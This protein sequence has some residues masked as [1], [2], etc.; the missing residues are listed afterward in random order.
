MSEINND[1]G[2]MFSNYIILAGAILRKIVTVLVC[3]F[4]VLNLFLRCYIP[5]EILYPHN[6]NKLPYVKVGDGDN[7]SARSTAKS[8][9]EFLS[10]FT[11]VSEDGFVY[12]DRSKDE[13]NTPHNTNKYMDSSFNSIFTAKDLSWVA[14]L[15]QNQ[16]K[17]QKKDFSTIFSMFF[18]SNLTGVKAQ[19]K[20]NKF[21]SMV[22]NGLFSNLKHFKLMFF[23][24]TLLLVTFIEGFID[25]GGINDFLNNKLDDSIGNEEVF[26][27]AKYIKDLILYVFSGFFFFLRFFQFLAIPFSIVLAFSYFT[28]TPI[29]MIFTKFFMMVFTFAF[30]PLIGLILADPG[31]IKKVFMTM[32]SF[33][34]IPK[35]L[36]KG[37][38]GFLTIFKIIG[39]F[40]SAFMG[41]LGMISFLPIVNV[42]M[43]TIV[44][45]SY[46][47]GLKW[48]TDTEI[49]RLC[50]GLFKSFL[51]MIKLM[52]IIF[53]LDLLYKTLGRNSMILALVL[54]VVFS[55]MELYTNPSDGQNNNFLSNLV[56]GD[57]DSDTTHVALN[58]LFQ[59]K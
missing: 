16:S 8:L 28:P 26:S 12:L 5:G 56:T 53:A 54:F 43:F 52:F 31:S 22:H 3:I 48:L 7:E 24:L 2:T 10:P 51:P 42:V 9:N 1:N 46:D 13:I 25:K 30:I 58:S 21:L 44:K 35:F 17:I 50:M 49:R 45:L 32:V 29:T 18:L 23:I 6:L 34:S 36:L 33:I 20:I 55:M 4:I 15:Y 41:L 59:K 47:L 27:L 39:W 40:I 37:D 19:A 38:I 11:K 14:S 57:I